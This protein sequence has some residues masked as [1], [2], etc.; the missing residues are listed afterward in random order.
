MDVVRRAR[1]H[2]WFDEEK[3]QY[4][5]HRNDECC[6]DDGRSPG[7]ERVS[8]CVFENVDPPAKEAHHEKTSEAPERAGEAAAYCQGSGRT[9]SQRMME[10]S[11]GH[12]SILVRIPVGDRRLRVSQKIKIAKDGRGIAL[13]HDVP[14][15]ATRILSLNFASYFNEDRATAR[16]IDAMPALP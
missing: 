14:T 5:S 9:P 4:R 10:R 16:G 6:A 8:E 13:L 3:E 7:V 1:L 15:G 11:A 2:S 12:R